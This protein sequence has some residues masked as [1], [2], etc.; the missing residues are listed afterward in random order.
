MILRSNSKIISFQLHSLQ[1]W[2]EQLAKYWRTRRLIRRW[3]MQKREALLISKTPY[4][5]KHICLK[6]YEM[7]PQRSQYDGYTSCP[8]VTSYNAVVMAEFDYKLQPLETF[9]IDQ[10]KESRIMYHV[11][12]DLMPHI[13]WQGLLK[14]VHTTTAPNFPVQLLWK[15]YNY[16]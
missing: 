10:G 14:Y 9:P 6:S 8:L 5:S 7:F 15:K 3:A 16:I 2:T 11:K 1:Y 12:A 4:I 13:Y